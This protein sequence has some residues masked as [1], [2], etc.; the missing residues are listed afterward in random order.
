MSVRPVTGEEERHALGH[1]ASSWFGVF[2]LLFGVQS[3][4]K[5]HNTHVNGNWFP[6]PQSKVYGAVLMGG[7]LFAGY[8]IGQ[9]LFGN[10]A[11][12]R[13]VDSHQLDAQ[14]RKAHKSQL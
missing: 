9:K 12:Q 8:F 13:L 10:P 11:L 4:L 1:P 3:H 7:G 2:G 14:A 6:T 5:I